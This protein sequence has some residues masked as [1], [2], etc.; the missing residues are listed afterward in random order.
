MLVLNKHINKLIC[1]KELINLLLEDKCS[2]AVSHVRS[3]KYR[4]FIII[5]H[6]SPLVSK[7]SK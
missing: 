4:N 1:S 7:V 3:E 6:F 5:L 2:K